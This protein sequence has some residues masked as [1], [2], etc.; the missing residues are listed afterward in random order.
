L[1]ALAVADAEAAGVFHEPRAGGDEGGQ[2]AVAG[3]IVQHLPRAGRQNEADVGMRNPAL[4]D[5][6][7]RHQ[8]LVGG[9]GAASQTDLLNGDAGQ[10]PDRGNI[11]GAVRFGGQRLNPGQVDRFNAGIHC[12]GIRFQFDKIRFPLLGAQKLPGQIIAGKHG[13]RHAAFRAHVGDG[14]ALRNAQRREAPA[15][16]FENGSDVALG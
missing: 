5:F 11:V 14:G 7:D 6:G 3:E 13:G 4:E 12:V 9:I 16:V 1:R 10:R 2:V 8:I 15:S